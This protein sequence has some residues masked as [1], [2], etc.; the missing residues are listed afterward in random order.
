ML[1]KSAAQP[2][3]VGM[4]RK[5]EMEIALGVMQ[6]AA[7]QANGLAT[8]KRC[9]AE[10]PS[11]LNLDAADTAFS[12]TRPGERMW[13]QQVRNIRSHYSA[14]GNAIERGWLEHVPRT[15]Y[16]ITETGRTHLKKKN[17]HP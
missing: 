12:G 13:H 8:F 11:I 14:D 2:E 16:R 5:D 6:V 3:E 9:R 7:G 17:L 10:L 15:G 1:Y 4:A